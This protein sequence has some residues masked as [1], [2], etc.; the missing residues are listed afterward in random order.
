MGYCIF[1]RS[2]KINAGPP[3]VSSLVDL[4]STNVL[5]AISKT[6]NTNSIM[7]ND[8]LRPVSHISLTLSIRRYPNLEGLRLTFIFLVTLEILHASQQHGCQSTSQ[9]SMQYAWRYKHFNTQFKSLA[10]VM[11]LTSSWRH[12][13][14]QI[15]LLWQVGPASKYWEHPE[16]LCGERWWLQEGL[17]LRLMW[18]WWPETVKND[19]ENT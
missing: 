13:L 6:A 5:S 7:A 14:C 9:I 11:E 18:S 1:L 10:N 4:V 16:T 2:T 19:V 12:W 15:K 17:Q 8:V 3:K